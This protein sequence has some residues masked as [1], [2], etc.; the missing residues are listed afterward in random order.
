MTM[1]SHVNDNRFLPSKQEIANHCPENDGTAEISVVGHEHQHEHQREC[2]L[3][4]MEETLVQM[5]QR[6][7]RW[8]EMRHN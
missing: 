6:E 5:H 4:E 7:H 3:D 2:H 8:P 1:L